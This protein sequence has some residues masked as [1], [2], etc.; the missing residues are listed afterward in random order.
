MLRPA[1]DSDIPQIVALERLP[2]SRKYVGQWSE[3]RHLR[4]LRSN[5][6]R[7]LV[8]DAGPGQLGAYVILRGFE[9]TEG[10]IELKRIV[11]GAPG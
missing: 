9:E 11:I 10:S 7:Y 3:D 5:D 4:T 1:E 8:H 2:E 6:A